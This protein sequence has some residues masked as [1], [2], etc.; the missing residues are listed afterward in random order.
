MTVIV[1]KGDRSIVG[2][3]TDELLQELERRISVSP[4]QVCGK[5]GRLNELYESWQ[6]VEEGRMLGPDGL[7]PD[8][9]GEH[10]RPPF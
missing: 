5:L 3:T 1:I 8:E 6:R 4:N 10:G 2:F 9:H 7:D